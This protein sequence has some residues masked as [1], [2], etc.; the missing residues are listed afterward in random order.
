MSAAPAEKGPAM[1][2][3]FP[4]VIRVSAFAAVCAAALSMSAAVPASAASSNC[5]AGVAC[6]PTAQVPAQS[7]SAA[8]TAQGKILQDK[9]PASAKADSSQSRWHSMSTFTLYNRNSAGVEAYLRIFSKSRP[10]VWPSAW[11]AWRMPAN[12][13]QYG[14]RISCI[15]GERI[16][17]GA[18]SFQNPRLSWGVGLYGVR[19]CSNCCYTCNG[20]YAAINLVR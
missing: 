15:R 3:S 1:T 14:V 4:N 19:Y 12:K 20:G 17:F 13:V 18:Q 2:F 9:A 16:C 11:T 8:P 10:W 5:V 6:A 7:R